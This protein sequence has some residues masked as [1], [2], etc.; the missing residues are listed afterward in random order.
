VAVTV[1]PDGVPTAAPPVFVETLRAIIPGGNGDHRLQ[2]WMDAKFGPDGALYLLDYGGGFFTLHANQK[3]I[4]IS[5]RGGAPTP[6]PSATSVA[7]Q[8]KPLTV[9]F[10]GSKSG[11]VSHRWDF[12]DDVLHRG[13]P[14]AHLRQA[15]LVRRG[16]DRAYADGERHVLPL[17]VDVGRAVADGGRGVAR[18]RRLAC[19]TSRSAAAARSTT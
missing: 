11:G 17:K 18:R 7:V 8:G 19:P 3:L 13:R 9:A 5:Y 4:R 1:D 12:G 15:R 16:A 10:T 2:S 6:A 14:A